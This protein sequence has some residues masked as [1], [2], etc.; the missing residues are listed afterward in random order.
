MPNSPTLTPKQQQVV[1]LLGK[2]RSVKQI[3]K[4]MKITES[5]V[6][7][8]IRRLRELGVPVTNH[9][10]PKIAGDPKGKLVDLSPT[11]VEPQSS[12]VQFNGSATAV[13][14]PTVLRAQIESTRALIEDNAA[15]IEN[16]E[17]DLARGQDERE[18][19]NDLLSRHAEALTAYQEK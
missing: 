15:Y 10:S 11:T 14:V 6:Y 17:R 7:G 1:D 9:P 8:H 2:K 4:T 16:T 12:D 5:G 18:R 19:L 13:D 3:A